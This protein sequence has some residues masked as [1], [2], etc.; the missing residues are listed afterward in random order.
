MSLKTL[1]KSDV[2]LETEKLE[3]K[4]VT[5][6]IGAE[7]TGVKLSPDLD[8]ET[9]RV[10]RLALLQYKVIFFRG[11]THL[12]NAGQEGFAELLGEPVAHPTVPTTPGS[13]YSLSISSIHGGRTNSWHTDVTFVQ[14]YPQASILRAETIPSAGGDTVWANT[15]T[16]LNDLSPELRE[17]A[18]KLRALHTNDYDYAATNSGITVEHAARFK[19]IFAA[20]VYETE[21][22]LV[23]VHP[24]TGEHALVLGHFIKKIVGLSSNDSARL[25][26]ILQGHVTRPE[27]T[28]RWRW[29][30]GDVA[31]WDN[32]ATQH[33]G[34][35]DYGD[36]LRVLQR[37]T[38]AG[39]IPVGVDGRASI[40]HKGP[41]IGPSVV[42]KAA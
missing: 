39:D 2:K 25:F 31:I 4:P 17:L 8:A 3:I 22:P 18:T 10:I 21:H 28:V 33:Y 16:A 19:N 5:G 32:R 36:Q 9:V 27:N 13:K 38:I 26:D 11:Q 6:R 41:N 37:V 40:A 23:R 29:T 12:D 42:E 14:A 7:I 34:V 1:W 20:T 24:E 15:V 35:N 30:P